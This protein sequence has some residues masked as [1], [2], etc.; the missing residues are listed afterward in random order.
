MLPWTVSLIFLYYHAFSIITIPCNTSYKKV[1]IVVK[2]EL[3]SIFE[4]TAIYDSMHIILSGND[5]KDLNG[6]KKIISP[7]SGHGTTGRDP[8][9]PL[10]GHRTHLSVTSNIS[11]FTQSTTRVFL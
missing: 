4:N 10:I 11:F 2:I 9:G 1:H 6:H 7:T 5:P 8:L 3:S